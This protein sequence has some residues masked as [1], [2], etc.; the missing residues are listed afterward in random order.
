VVLG[1]TASATEACDMLQ[2]LADKDFEGKVLPFAPRDSVVV[3]A[4]QERAEK[5]GIALL[6]PLLMPLSNEGLR[7]SIATLLP[8]ESSGPV[9]DMAEAVR[10]VGS[11]FGTSRKSTRVRSS[12]AAPKRSCA[13]AI[14]LGESFHLLILRLRAAAASTL[15]RMP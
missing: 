15:S 9:V 14:R 1:L 13:F 12:C 10:E 3:G 7:E 5:L 8:E 2:A 4:V 6:P 11:S